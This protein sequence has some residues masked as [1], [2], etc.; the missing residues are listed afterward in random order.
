MF[1][2]MENGEVW[3]WN[4]DKTTFFYASL[5]QKLLNY[6]YENG[7][8]S[9]AGH[10]ND[11]TCRTRWRMIRYLL[12]RE[13]WEWNLAEIFNHLVIYFLQHNS[14]YY[15]NM[16]TLFF[17]FNWKSKYF[18]PT[19]FRIFICFTLKHLTTL[20]AQISTVEKCFGKIDNCF[21][22][23]FYWLW[24]VTQFVLGRKKLQTDNRYSIDWNIL[25]YSKIRKKM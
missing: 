13:V 16:S 24:Q 23:L 10:N 17:P 19:M 4:S 8:W 15:N 12:G 6:L 14:S 7:I 5:V 25:C 1:N 22:R 2:P 20:N 21:L 9:M 18:W 11:Q 3:I